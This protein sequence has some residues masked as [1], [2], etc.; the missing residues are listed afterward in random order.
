[1]IWSDLL[2]EFDGEGGVTSLW[3]RRFSVKNFVRE[4]LLTQ[5]DS[6]RIEALGLE[7]CVAL[8][9]YALKAAALGH[10]TGDEF[11]KLRVRER[12]NRK[13]LEAAKKTLAGQPDL[14]NEVA[15]LKSGLV[16]QEK[17]FKEKDE[18]VKKQL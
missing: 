14:A 7:A 10:I 2:A 17:K 5:D 16:S 1:M 13:E 3:D 8:Q 9:S 12:Q 11:S 18:F 4:K 6:S 15:R